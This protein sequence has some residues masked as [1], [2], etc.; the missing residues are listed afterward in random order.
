MKTH[1]LPDA[2]YDR[3]GRVGSVIKGIPIEWLSGHVRGM[4]LQGCPNPVVDLFSSCTSRPKKFGLRSV[5]TEG[6]G[7]VEAT[8][9]YVTVRTEPVT[10]GGSS[11]PGSGAIYL[12]PTTRLSHS[13]ALESVQR[14][15]GTQN[16]GG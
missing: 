2:L 8:G 1:A 15:D 14:W 10:P 6:F 5:R 3:E 7:G 11:F 16:S 13:R 9:R 12:Q 4:L